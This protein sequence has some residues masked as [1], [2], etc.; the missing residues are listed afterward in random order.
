MRLTSAND[1]NVNYNCFK[2]AAK[3]VDC[4]KNLIG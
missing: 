3:I 2:D 4:I 1:F